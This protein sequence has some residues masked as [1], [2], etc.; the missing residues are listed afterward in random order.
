MAREHEV[1]AQPIRLLDVFFVGPVMVLAGRKLARTDDLLGNVLTALGV[2]T[3]WYNGRNYLR[4]EEE[5]R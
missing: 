4:I 5:R 3:I 2:L 1:K